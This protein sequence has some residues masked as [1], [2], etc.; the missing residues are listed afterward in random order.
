VGDNQLSWDGVTVNDNNAAILGNNNTLLNGVGLDRIGSVQGNTNVFIYNFAYGDMEDYGANQ[1]RTR[2]GVFSE[3]MRIPWTG[4]PDILAI[5]ARHAPISSIDPKFT[6]A[7]KDNV[8]A[9]DANTIRVNLDQRIGNL[10]VRLGYNQN[11][12]DNNTMYSNTSPNAY[13]YD[14]NRLRPDGTPNRKFMS[15]HT[16]VEQNNRYD[17]DAVKEYSFL[18]NYTFAIPRWWDYTQKLALNLSQRDSESEN[19][20]RAW[21]RTDNPVNL[22]PNN[23]TNRFY[24]RVYFDEP[25]ATEA[26][27]L[28][29]PNG[30]VPGTWKY[31]ETGGGHTDRQVRHG[32]V[33]SQSVFFNQ[34]LSFTTSYSKDKVEADNQT[35]I[36]G[37]GAPDYA[38]VLGAN[39]VVGAH[40]IRKGSTNSAAFG[41]VAYPF[42]FKRDGFL[43]KYISPLGVVFNWGEN[44]QSPGTST[45]A[46]L[47]DGSEPPIPHARTKDYALR[48]LVPGGKVSLEVRHYNTDSMDQSASFGSASSIANIW[49]NLG[50]TD[51]KLITTTANS[52]FNYSDP[53]S[54][55]LEGWEAEMTANPTRNIS[56]TLNYSHPLSYISKE[57]EDRKIYYAEHLDEWK[58]GAAAPAGSILNGRQIINPQVIQNSI[59]SIESSLASLTGGTLDNGRER[60][61]INAA[62]RYRFSDGFLKGLTVNAGVQY[63]SHTKSGSRDARLKFGLPDTPGSPAP[64]SLQT[65]QAAFDYLWTPSQWKHTLTAGANYQRKFGKY[66]YRFQVNVTNVLN[67]LDP[68]WG[69]NGG[70]SGA[71]DVVPSNAFG[72]INPRTQVKI[73]FVPPD[74]RKI[75]F[76]STV[77]F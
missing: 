17:Q 22:D 42:Q 67:V 7:A 23:G 68:I 49:L 73:N 56:L 19:A 72:A 51:P 8:A 12:F 62:G 30:L 21:R 33:T 48:Y 63:R 13:R 71:Y 74:P 59:D 54:R 10:T 25:R 53:S 18:A 77:S 47:I 43:K 32:G 24:Y 66:N 27:I 50:Y 29:N 70:S 75:I 31:I 1:Y 14:V 9:R 4:N 11:S 34:K 16:D 69:R 60:H 76:T 46:P 65:A 6:A 45:Q 26:P 41:V 3:N 44:N 28:T 36:S 64:T 40:A 37:S 15:P 35:R 39:N 61:R 20:T 58:A 55:K 2:N 5:P 52:G 38:N 57:S